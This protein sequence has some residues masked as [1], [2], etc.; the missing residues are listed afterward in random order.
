MR[1]QAEFDDEHIA[2]AI[3]LPLKSIDASSVGSNLK[4]DVSVIVY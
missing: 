2:G 1:P 4:R 3:F